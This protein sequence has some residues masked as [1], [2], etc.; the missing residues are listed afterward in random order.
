LFFWEE[1]LVRWRLLEDE[2][3][4]IVKLVS[5]LGRMMRVCR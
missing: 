5:D 1:E 4:D 3:A 2:E